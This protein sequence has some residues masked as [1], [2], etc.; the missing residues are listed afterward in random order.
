MNDASSSTAVAC[1]AAEGF[2]PKE[3]MST[4]CGV[5]AGDERNALIRMRYCMI[6]SGL[7][8]LSARR[9]VSWLM[10]NEMKYVESSR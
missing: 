10:E 3:S 8:A 6:L 9:S 5:A 4:D 1:A 7:D 2:N